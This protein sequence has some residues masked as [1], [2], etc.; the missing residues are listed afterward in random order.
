MKQRTT[1]GNMYKNKIRKRGLSLHPSTTNQNPR[2]KQPTPKGAVLIPLQVED[3]AT[4]NK[5]MDISLGSK[6]TIITIH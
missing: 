2:K 5:S 3:L 6:T 1:L 4:P